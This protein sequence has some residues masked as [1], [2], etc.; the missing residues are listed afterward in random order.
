MSE[1]SKRTQKIITGV[2]VDPP[3]RSSRRP[4][5]NEPERDW[6]DE[7]ASTRDTDTAIGPLPALPKLQK[8][9]AALTVISGPATGRVFSV[10]GV[11][12]L[13]RG[14]EVTVH[15]DDAGVSRSHAQV[16]PMPDGEYLLE[17]LGSRNGTF[18]NSKRIDR[19]LLES[20]DRI[21]VGPNIAVT[22]AIL[23]AQ[24]EKIA[25]QI[26][27]SSVRDPLTRAFNRRYLVDR[28]GSE[29]AYAVRHK[30]AL[31]LILLDLDH[32]KQVNDTYGH[33]VGDDVLRDVAALIQRFI[34]VEDVFARFGGEEFVVLVRGIE[35]A[36]VG[37]FAERIR[38][39]VEGLEIASD[40]AVLRVTMSAGY[41]SLSEL[42]ARGDDVGDDLMR[43][44]DE[45]LYRS[46]DA[47]RNRVTGA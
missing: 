1:D 11:M 13:G 33:L 8:T 47:G 14:R 4:G 6:E 46:K 5:I 12:L 39:A 29:I 40:P 19:T 15:L 37:L 24:A 34:R 20:G 45:R 28:L 7:E 32:F 27:E 21:H 41:A 2:L 31:G 38:A 35:H 23:D 25:Q 3:P 9:R 10:E 43:L 22:F 16:T 17:D 44:A 36:N 42:E 30:T 26:Y 18:V